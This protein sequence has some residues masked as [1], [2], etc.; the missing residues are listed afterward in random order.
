MI[1]MLVLSQGVRKA[2]RQ[3][4]LYGYLV[5]RNNQIYHPGALHPV[6]TKLFAFH[7]VQGGWLTKNGDRYELTTQGREASD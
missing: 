4:R 1:V 5:E 2:L 6:C 7:M 3:A